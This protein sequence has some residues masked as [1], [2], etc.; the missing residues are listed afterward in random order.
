MTTT[1]SRR[2]VLMLAGAAAIA[3]A[4]GSAP[5]NPERK[6]G[7]D[8][9]GLFPIMATPYTESKAVD[10]EDLAHEV[11]FL[12]RCGVPGMVWPQLLGETDALTV[13]ERKRGMEV[14]A[15]SAKGRSPRI[16]LGVD[17]PN[18]RSAMA[19]LEHAEGLDPDAVIAMPPR[20]AKSAAEVMDY[21]RTLV[22]ATRRP[23][24]I[25]SAELVRGVRVETQA[26]VDLAREY[27]HAAYFKEEVAP[28]IERMMKLAEHKPVVRR[29]F[30][31]EGGRNL[32]YVLRLGLD[33]SMAGHSVADVLVQVWEL[34]EAGHREKSRDLYAKFLLF[35]NCE[36]YVPGTRQYMMKK[37]GIF[38]TTVSR[39]AEFEYSREGLAELDF[40]YE[41]LKPHFKA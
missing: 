17:G 6:K 20:E 3:P 40:H 28:S 23:F 1:I 18:L 32:M 5:K 4:R 15:K 41:A 36:S 26:L 35:L 27:P 7:S 39:R 12:D 11:E 21:Y 19:Y 34:W 8:F 22:K 25:Q 29:V 9:R 2:E 14:I 31:G 24:F 30:A 38:K 33:G 37:R 10:Y 16:V 13:E